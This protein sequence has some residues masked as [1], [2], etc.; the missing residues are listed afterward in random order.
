M[1]ILENRL[2]IIYS[3]TGDFFPLKAFDI[4]KRVWA[5]KLCALVGAEGREDEKTIYFFIIEAA[6]R[7]GLN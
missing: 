4:R 2:Y 6:S 1:S 5:K 7:P 3:R